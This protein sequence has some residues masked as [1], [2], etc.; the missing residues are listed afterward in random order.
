MR[1]WFKVQLKDK[2]KDEAEA[3]IS[4]DDFI[5]DW[6]DNYWGFGVT[7]K[8]FVSELSAMPDEV[9]NIKV[10]INSPGGDVFAA[11][12]IANALRQWASK[13]GRTVETYVEGLA[14]S[15]ASVIAMAGAPVKMADNSLMMVHEPWSGSVGRA[16]EMRKAADVLD[17]VR[18]AAVATYQW[19]TDKSADDIVAMLEAE[20]WMDADE[21]IEA[22]FADE[23]V[24]G[25]RAAASIDPKALDS[26]KIPERYVA[27]VKSFLRAEDAPADPPLDPPPAPV[28]GPIEEPSTPPV[29]PPPADAA[30]L[31]EACAKA[32]LDVAAIKAL[33]TS[34]P[35]MDQAVVAIDKWKADRKAEQDRADTIRAACSLAHLED[36]AESVVGLGCDVPTAKLFLARL[37]AKLDN[38]E[39]DST[40]S[41]DHGATRKPVIDTNAIYAERNGLRKQE[42]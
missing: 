31:V 41:P 34:R 13:G 9:R 6:I 38:I 27:R 24:E 19:H 15:A 39:I 30:E 1:E 3:E 28:E 32:G 42:K 16:S 14:A 8:A 5:G 29:N 7:A 36:L 4:V 18:D 23:K 21:A 25:L 12:Q 10:R 2:G 20:T 40:L 35:T 11:T 37:K 26:L 22:G 17:R 33:V